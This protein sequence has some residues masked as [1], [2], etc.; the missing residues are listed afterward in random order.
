V[1]TGLR[2]RVSFRQTQILVHLFFALEEGFGSRKEWFFF[3][4]FPRCYRPTVPRGTASF[5]PPPPPLWEGSPFSPPLLIVPRSVAGP[6]WSTGGV[7]F[8]L[9]LVTRFVFFPLLPSFFSLYNVS[10]LYLPESAPRIIFPCGGKPALE[11]RP[12]ESRTPALS[13]FFVPLIS[14]GGRR[15]TAFC[16]EVFLAGTAP[17]QRFSLT[18]WS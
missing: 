3:F 14:V 11:L 12:G 18:F 2:R 16:F 10:P 5:P 4:F 1:P 6:L 9:T 17:P 8:P 15:T 13:I 7:S